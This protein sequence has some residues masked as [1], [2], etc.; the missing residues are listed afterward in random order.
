[1]FSHQ[2]NRTDADKV[3]TVVHNVDGASITT[4][5][6]V[7]YVGGTGAE[8]VSADGIQAVKINAAADC[9]NFAGI[10]AQD[11]ADTEYG[12]VQ[13]WGY[14]DSIMLSHEG[15]SVTV[16]CLAANET[17]LLPGPP[18]GT[19]TSLQIPQG[20]STFG[21]KYVQVWNTTNVSAQA[22]CKGFVR[23]L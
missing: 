8:V 10:A 11:I 13:C 3:F 17:I 20:L 2:V 1:M 18:N 12:L 21:F 4:G 6:G 16:G 23:A 15:T 22:W 5:H 7:R 19:W 9:Y 14:V